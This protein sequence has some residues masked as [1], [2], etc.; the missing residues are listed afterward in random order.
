MPN[1][2]PKTITENN[3]SDFLIRVKRFRV[4]IFLICLIVFIPS[5]T[6]RIMDAYINNLNDSPIFMTFVLVYILIGIVMFYKF[7]NMKC[8]RCG[9]GYFTKYDYIPK[10]MYKLK[11][12]NCGLNVFTK[13]TAC[14]A[15]AKEDET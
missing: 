4:K 8:P 6:M 5:L 15:T 10:L 3:Y 1:S 7:L 2:M 13:I 11:C 14:D 9:E 12:Q